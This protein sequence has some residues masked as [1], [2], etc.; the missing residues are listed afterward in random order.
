MIKVIAKIFIKAVRQL[1]GVGPGYQSNQTSLSFNHRENFC[2]IVSKLFN[3]E[4]QRFFSAL[5]FMPFITLPMLIH[6]VCS[7]RRFLLN[8]PNTASFVYF[9]SFHNTMTNIAQI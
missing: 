9:R 6:L 1:V 8:G 5:Q 7:L 2:L 4:F 3:F